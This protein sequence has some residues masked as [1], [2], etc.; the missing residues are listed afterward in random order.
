M[1]VCMYVRTCMCMC[2]C[3]YMYMY[4]YVYICIDNH[5][6][7]PTLWGWKYATNTWDWVLYL[8]VHPTE[9]L[10]SK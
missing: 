8:T 5:V 6:G 10:V 3:M 1:Y 7:G 4:M 2:M 9:P